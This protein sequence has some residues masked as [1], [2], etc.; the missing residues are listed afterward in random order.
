MEKYG[1][2]I[3]AAILAF[4]MLLLGL[5]IK[6]GID[7][8]TNK[9]RRVTVKGL[10]EKVVDSDEV[11]WTLS[12]SYVGDNLNELFNIL[13]GKIA[14]I[15][16]YLKENG[17]DGKATVKVNSFDI[18]DNN[19]NVWSERRPA[20]RYSVSRSLSVVSN[21]TKFIAELKDKTADALLERGHD[22]RLRY[23]DVHRKL[24]HTAKL[25]FDLCLDQICKFIHFTHLHI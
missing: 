19:A 13:N 10:A 25:L 12:V 3:Y 21:D 18:T 16:K 9:D 1:K 7:N 4:G 5:C 22:R 24:T 6:S 23:A 11:T 17:I 2:L 8:F 20:F 14:D 15:Q